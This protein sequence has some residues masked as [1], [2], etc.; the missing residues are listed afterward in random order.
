MNR[1]EFLTI[2]RNQL[3]GQMQE[4][5]AEAHIRY[6]EDYIQSQVRKGRTEEDVL[7]EL[8]DPRLIAKTLIETEDS[9]PQAGYGQYSSYGSG[10]EESVQPE[11]RWKKILDL[12]TWQGKAVVIVGAV[13]AMILILLVI[14]AVLPFFIVLTIVLSILSWIKKHTN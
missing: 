9:Q 6:Y 2:L 7:G 8:G 10:V 12:S 3:A 4:G 1:T 11:K 14:G 13:L 5:K